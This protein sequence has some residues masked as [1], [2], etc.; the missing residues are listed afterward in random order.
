MPSQPN[1]LIQEKS[2]YLLQ[3]AYNPVDWYPWGKEALARAKED[4][5]LIF[6][7]IGYSTCHWCHVME[8]ESF[9]DLEVARLMNEG[10]V[11]IKVDREERPDLD[12]YF[13]GVCQMLTGSGGWPLT[14]VLTPDG[15]PFFAGT[16]FPKTSRFG[17][18]GMKEL[19]PSIRSLW[20][21]RAEEVIKSTKAIQDV[22]AQSAR[23]IQRR[24]LDNEILKSAFE[25]FGESFD[26]IHGGFRPP[27]KFP[28]PHNLLFLLR[29]GKRRRQEKA[30][31]MV[32]QTLTAMR[33]GG[34]YDQLGF[35]FHRY[36]TDGQWLI[37]HFEKMLYDQ[38]L[39]ALVYTEA[40][41]A[42]GIALYEQT[43]REILS[44]V[45]RDMTSPD[46]GFYS[47]EDADVAG[48]EGRFYIWKEEEIRS[49]LTAEETRLALA[50]FNIDPGGNFEGE[51]GRGGAQNIL[52]L[53]KAPQE[54][55]K[56][57]GIPA[58]EFGAV[59]EKIRGKLFAAREKR[60]RP[61]KDKKILADWNGLMIAATARAGQALG[62]KVYEAAAIKAAEFVLSGMGD[63][64]CRLW[65]RSIDGQAKISGFLDD[66]AFFIWGLLELYETVFD[67]RYLETALRFTRHTLDRF[68][69]GRN[70]GFYFVSDEST[71]LPSR[72]KEIHDGA[73]PSGNSVMM[74]NLL[75]LGRM[76]GD[77][78][79]EQKASDIAQAFAE[80]ISRSPSSHAHLMS[81]L[82]FAAGPTLEIVLAGNLDSADTQ[83]LLRILRKTYLPGK[84][85]LFRPDGVPN[86]E[87]AKISPFIK[88]LTSVDGKATAYVCSN[89]RCELPITDPKTLREYLSQ[90]IR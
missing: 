22:L 28:T 9:E 21:N 39:L 32:E 52:H 38:A 25:Q 6:L 72:P 3:H 66:Y 54:L 45:L 69:D 86:P 64:E 51:T 18:P 57:L 79:F 48:E 30:V 46:G 20:G 84:V 29:Y 12:H 8:R 42:T 82:D 19:L 10:F 73:L 33:L 50:V 53:K 55:S 1:R 43:V 35:G 61:P 23:G 40:Y 65:H 16:Y 2:P 26:G 44:Y 11:S 56:D 60:P 74:N 62:V 47:A 89:F 4:G 58:E 34:I 36:S 68:W 17:L 24:S 41:Q 83:Q 80:T 59:L 7:S 14:I 27:P 77:P 71:D 13:M 87:I 78:S 88:S 37:P 31:R 75:R 70:G 15:R 5:K 90:S 81:G 85:L 67:V 49:I 76:T 63:G